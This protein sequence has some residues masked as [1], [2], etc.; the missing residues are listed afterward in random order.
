ME[1]PA[2]LPRAFYVPT[3]E[4]VADSATLLTR[5]GT[6][7]HDPRRV[8][9]IETRPADGFLGATPPGQGMATIRTDRS[10]ELEIDL[11]ADAPGFLFLSD[12]D[13]PGWE[14]TVNDVP[15]PILRA[16]Y[17]FRL[18]R[19][20]A[21]ASRVVFRYRPRSVRVGALL[22]AA[23][24]LVLGLIPMARRENPAAAMWQ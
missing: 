5:L 24:L 3:A 10:E 16:N 17:A 2:A 12:Q 18:V 9:L 1:N 4:V 6:P 13:F 19:V 14:A 11:V 22:S 23:T 7:A 15:A 8:A 20:P 21:G